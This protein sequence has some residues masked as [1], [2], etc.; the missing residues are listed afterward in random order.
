MNIEVKIYFNIEELPTL[1]VE[2]YEN[3]VDLF[4]LYKDIPYYK[5]FLLIAFSEGKPVASLFS[6]IMR[7]N[8]FFGGSFFKRCYINQ[9]PTFF[10]AENA[11]VDEIF[12][13]LIT[14][15]YSFA[16][17]QAF[18]LEVHN[19]ESTTLGYGIFRK[20]HF[21]STKKINIKV[22]INEEIPVWNKL[23]LRKRAQ[24]LKS[25]RI[26]LIIEELSTEEELRILYNYFEKYNNWKFVHQLPPYKYF[27]NFYHQMTV[28][29]KGN[30]FLTLYKNKIIGGNIVALKNDTITN[31]F[32]WSHSKRYAKLHPSTFSLWNLVEYGEKNG[33]K[34]ID[35]LES[36]HFNQK[37]GRV[38]KLIN[39]GGI[40][41]ATRRWYR[42][43]WKVINYFMSKMYND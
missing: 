13:E 42:F 22:Q 25:Q 6:Y 40:E 5:P 23:S 2:Q 37:T 38:K 10:Y 15:W 43:N 28:R 41:K 9:P 1:P 33:Y 34:T 29:N 26:G 35:F 16:K 27:E 11:D 8:R 19:L 20:F 32:D 17:R 18:Y 24:V 4:L 14:K 36:G 3:C 39:M 31:L 12:K 21:I 7:I 30:I